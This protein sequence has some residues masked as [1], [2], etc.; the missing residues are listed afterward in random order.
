MS[1]VQASQMLRDILANEFER[2]GQESLAAHVRDGS[3]NSTGGEAALRA[4]VTLAERMSMRPEARVAVFAAIDG[5]RD[6]QDARKKENGYDKQPEHELA[7]FLTYMD[8]YLTEAKHIMTRD[9]GRGCYP[10][11]LNVVRK[12]VSLG[13]AAME[14][15]G[16]VRRGDS[17]PPAPEA[18]V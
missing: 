4:M 2:V 5:E 6:Y 12:V 18:R 15:H 11:T 9:W 10:R 16:V 7:A 8:N 3:D 13:V 1:R 14:T 17:L